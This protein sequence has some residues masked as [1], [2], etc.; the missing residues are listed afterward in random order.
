[1]TQDRPGTRGIALLIVLFGLAVISGVVV[2][3]SNAGKVEARGTANLVERAGLRL[4]ADAGVALATKSLTDEEQGNAWPVDGRAMDVNFA[5][6]PLA[7][8]ITDVSGL[9]DVNTG[10]ADLLARLLAVQGG[11]PPARA[12][13][14]VGA[15]R[16]WSDADDR[17]Q[18]GGVE[19]QDYRAAGLNY[20]P[21]NRPLESLAELPMVAGF[22]AEI[23][24]R[25][26]PFLTVH[27][28]LP[29]VDATVAPE[30]VLAAVPGL[31]AAGAARLVALREAGAAQTDPAISLPARRAYF[32]AGTRRIF[33]IDVE[34]GAGEG[35]LRRRTIVSTEAAARQPWRRL[36]QYDLPY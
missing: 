27:S 8:R 13:Q 23:W 33:A 24:P 22:P 32:T 5:G 17:S 35:R 2:L 14:I 16:D 20:R 26:L 12:I 29:G 31:D 9:I 19:T 25:V 3:V 21:P 6:I 4:A 1:M 15:I 36:A 34:A 28:A 18:S 11:V 10:P 7:V 30:A